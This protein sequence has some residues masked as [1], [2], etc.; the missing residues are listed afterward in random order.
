MG[1]T[2]DVYNSFAMAQRRSLSQMQEQ[3]VEIVGNRLQHE[4]TLEFVARIFLNIV[5]SSLVHSK[6]P[7]Q[8]EFLALALYF[9][10][11]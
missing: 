1:A 7:S 4:A 3:A 6:Q 10:I 2:I 9:S 11:A 5:P 8:S